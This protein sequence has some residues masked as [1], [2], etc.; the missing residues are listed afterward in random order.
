MLLYKFDAVSLLFG[1]MGCAIPMI[2]IKN[3]IFKLWY[4]T[5]HIRSSK[6]FTTKGFPRPSTYTRHGVYIKTRIK[7]ISINLTII[8]MGKNRDRIA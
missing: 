2:I 1:N 5:Y 7:K 3:F 4:G 8:R 6:C